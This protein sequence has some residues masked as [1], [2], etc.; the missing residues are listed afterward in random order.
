MTQF[1][2]EWEQAER[3]QHAQVL[4]QLKREL[5][6]K[7]QAEQAQRLAPLAVSTERTTT[8]TGRPMAR[9]RH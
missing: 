8:T 9:T 2:Y 1:A 5:A 3:Q 6:A 4:Y 7:R